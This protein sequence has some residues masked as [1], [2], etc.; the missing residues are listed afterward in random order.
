M[1]RTLLDTPLSMA[2]RG[3]VTEIA[4]ALDGWRKGRTDARPGVE[5]QVEALDLHPS[6]FDCT[7]IVEGA[8]EAVRENAEQTGVKVI[9]ALVGAVPKCARGSAIHIHQL[10]TMLAASLR[11]FGCAENVEVQVA[12]EPTQNGDTEMVL[13]FVILTNS[14]DEKLGVRLTR[15][16][17]QCRTLQPL[18]AELTLTSAW[19]LAL[20]LGGRPR[21]ET[22][23]DKTVGVSIALPLLMGCSSSED[24]RSLGGAILSRQ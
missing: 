15:L 22:I 16:T 8:L 21:I 19:Q 2:Q 3:L 12:F 18:G 14:N 5:F 7:R 1:V 20:A 6:E 24:G 4:C 11:D 9:T 23:A 13:S 10:I 17:E